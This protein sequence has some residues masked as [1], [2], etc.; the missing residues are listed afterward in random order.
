LKFGSVTSAHSSP[1]SDA[2]QVTVAEAVI[3]AAPPAVML[4]LHETAALAVIEQDP[5]YVIPP[6]AVTV[7]EQVIDAAPGITI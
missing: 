4:A 6:L 7:A 3:D 1:C 2:S 5:S